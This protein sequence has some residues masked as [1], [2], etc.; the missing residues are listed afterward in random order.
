MEKHVLATLFSVFFS[1]ISLAQID[2]E[3]GYFI[4]EPDEKVQCLI[5]NVDWKNNPTGFRY[6]LSENT[7]VQE[8]GI[9]TVKEF[10]ITG[11]SKYVRAD[12]KLDIS[13]KAINKLSLAR[14]PHFQEE[15]VFLK[16]LIE[17]PVTL[18]SYEDRNITR[19][20]Y[21]SGRSKIVP[22]IYKQ[23]MTDN[24][25]AT[26]D[27]YKKQLLTNFYTHGVTMS[28]LQYLKYSTR[29][30]ERLFIKIN[31]N[32][33]SGFTNFED[34]K[35]DVFNLTLKPGV[36]FN[37]LNVQYNV[38]SF[39][40]TNF[41]ME[42]NFR[43]G[44]EAEFIFPFYRNK[45]GVLVEPSY[46]YYQAEH[47]A[48]WDRYTSEVNYQ[49][50]EF[51]GGIRHYFFLNAKSKIYLNPLIVYDFNFN[52]TY[53]TIRFDGFLQESLKIKSG[54]NMAAVAGY[55]Y[56]DKYSMEIRYYTKRELLVPYTHWSSSYNSFS[57]T[58]GYTVF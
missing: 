39:L 36:N 13:D 15:T 6:K 54:M 7:P 56:N 31:E 30:L 57:V 9:R 29:D 34:K 35:K 12:V 47:P 4:R 17:G 49:S 19:Y 3:S 20:F 2:F 52:S 42:Q 58:L 32:S 55:N 11:F 8:A 46:Q 33:G 14:E 10:G 48:S 16:V 26:N 22:L 37:K 18:L 50:I 40:F 43:L 24:G 44:V 27:D 1:M 5:R 53:K 38:Y 28:D 23:Y 51:A 21:Q 45:L 41:D 25:V